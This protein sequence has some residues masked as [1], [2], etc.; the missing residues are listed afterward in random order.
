MPPAVSTVTSTVPEEPAGLVTEIDVLDTEV[1]MPALP[2]KSTAVSPLRLVPVTVTNVPPTVDPDGGD[3]PLTVGGAMYVNRSAF[4][5]ADTPPAVV[6]VTAMAP[7][8]SAGLVAVID[9]AE[10]A[11]T[12]AGVVPKSTKDAPPKFVPLIVTAVPP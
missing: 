9:V 5:I 11:V 7:A 1:T 2:P 4:E 10:S 3:T 12:L 8:D 6:T